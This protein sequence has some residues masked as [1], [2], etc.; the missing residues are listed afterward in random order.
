MRRK[1]TEGWVRRVSDVLFTRISLPQ[2]DDIIAVDAQSRRISLCARRRF[3]NNVLSDD[4]PVDFKCV[5]YG[6]V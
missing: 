1:D 2:R 4:R 6:F 5:A 3:G